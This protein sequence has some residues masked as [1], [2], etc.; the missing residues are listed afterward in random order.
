M[1][2]FADYDFFPVDL[3]PGC[4]AAFLTDNNLLLLNFPVRWCT[5]F[6]ANDNLLLIHFTSWWCTSILTNDDFFPVDLPRSAGLLSIAS[7]GSGCLQ[8]LFLGSPHLVLGTR[9]V[10]VPR[11]S[12]EQDQSLSRCV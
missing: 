12:V 5:P 11:F 3:L 7:S 10:E 9:P 2:V 8:Y 1:A 6:V 4:F